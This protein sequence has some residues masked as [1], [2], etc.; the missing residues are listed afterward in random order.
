MN[1]TFNEEPKP[2]YWNNQLPPDF[3]DLILNNHKFI[4]TYFPP[5]DMSL[6]SKTQDNIYTDTVN[7]ENNE[8]KIKAF[9]GQSKVVW[10]RLTDIQPEWS[11]FGSDINPDQI[12]QGYIGNCYFLS[13][14][15]GSLS[16][17][18]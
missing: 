7:G 9:L 18:Y 15:F 8:N 3:G 13:L 5:N 4:D 12:I 14:F 17:Y 11:L 1:T 6:Y 2:K 10:K 16:A